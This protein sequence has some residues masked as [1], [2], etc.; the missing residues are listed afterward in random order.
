MLFVYLRA[1]VSSWSPSTERWKRSMIK[2]VGVIGA[3]TMGNGIAQVFAQSGLHRAP[4]RRRAA[5]A[6]PRARLDREEP[7]AVRREGQAL[8]R[9]R[10]ATLGAPDDGTERRAPRRRRLHRRSDRREGGRQARALCRPRRDR[11]ARCHPRLEHLV[12]LDHAAR[13][14]DQAARQGARHA[15]HEPGAADDAGRD[16]PR[17]GDLRRVDADRVGS[18]HGARQD[19]GRSRRLSRASSPTGS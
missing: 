19:A 8:R 9:D 4:G 11:A 13:R 5:D 17:P 16:D 2:T 6:R 10:D 18:V 14:G 7:R 12:D 1:F 15:L 3:G